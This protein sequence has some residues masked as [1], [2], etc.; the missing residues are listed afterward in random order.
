MALPD[1]TKHL[2]LK[3]SAQKRVSQDQWKT[4]ETEDKDFF[5]ELLKEDPELKSW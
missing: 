1:P 2:D 3:L 5:I 4:V